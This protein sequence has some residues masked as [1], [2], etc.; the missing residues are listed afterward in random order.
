MPKDFLDIKI[1]GDREVL[2]ALRKLPDDA[3]EELAQAQQRTAQQLAER[4]RAAG[5]ADTR[6]SARAATT[7]RAQTGAQP[8]V[9]AGPHPMLFG[10][11]FG[12]RRR[13]GWYARR[14]YL[15]SIPRQYRAH[16]GSASYWFFRT[17]EEG[18]AW[19]DQQWADVADT[20]VR[21]WSA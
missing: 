1:Q 17:Q 19:L 3:R 13:T 6:Q 2:R 14:R 15:D 8:V 21:Q 12:I 5:F 10:S 9:L 11:E 16:Q 7:V 18:R 20:V 4:V